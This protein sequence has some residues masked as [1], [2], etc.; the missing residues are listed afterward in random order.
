MQPPLRPMRLGEI[1]DKT[2]VI[3]RKGFFLF[4]GIVLLSS[5]GSLAI[6]VSSSL[7]YELALQ[8]NL[9]NLWVKAFAK[10]PLWLPSWPSS[11][12]H[13]LIWPILVYVA[14]CFFL[15]QRTSLRAAIPKCTMRWQS[16]LGFGAVLFIAWVVVP[17]I[18][19]QPLWR[20]RYEHF[21]PHPFG[22]SAWWAVLAY[23][24]PFDLA[25]WIARYL[26]VLALGFSVPVWSLE[27]TDIGTAL[28]R[29]W[30]LVKGNWFRVLAAMVMC[31]AVLKVL[32][33]SLKGLQELIFLILST[34]FGQFRL[35]EI[36]A[37]ELGVF[38]EDAAALLAVPL[39]PIAITLIYYDV[40][41]RREGF[42]VETLMEAAGLIT[43]E[44]APDDGYALQE[45]AKEI[46]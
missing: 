38:A 44:T 24:W 2:F 34:G 25:G 12:A 15:K 13:I 9:G 11:F 1:L 4:L 39:L 33:V 36:Y 23:Q 31:S 6:G 35:P 16:W 18:V 10:L 14:S 22:L 3:Y 26:L 40:R 30:T 46:L 8:L 28:R 7:L 19:M 43:P 20:F 21:S 27:G 5:A 42:G 32:E 17:Q 37:L 41:I 29:G 45:Q